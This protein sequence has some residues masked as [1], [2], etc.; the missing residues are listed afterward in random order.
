MLILIG[1]MTARRIRALCKRNVIYIRQI[2]V[3]HLEW[4]LGYSGNFF[5]N[6]SMTMKLHIL[7]V[8]YDLESHAKDGRCGLSRDEDIRRCV[9]KL[10]EKQTLIQMCNWFYLNSTSALKLILTNVLR[11]AQLMA[12]EWSYSGNNGKRCIRCC[13]RVNQRQKKPRCSRC[14]GILHK[15]K[16]I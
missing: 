16:S 7:N 10:V 8:L 15:I 5:N 14:E 3:K 9:G 11:K 6:G 13:K 12:N 1:K 4:T 2:R